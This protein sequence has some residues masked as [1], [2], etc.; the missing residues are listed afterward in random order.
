MTGTPPNHTVY[1]LAFERDGMQIYGNLY[2][3]KSEAEQYPITIIG[4][5]GSTISS[6]EYIHKREKTM[7]T[8]FV[9]RGDD[10][11]SYGEHFT[12]ADAFSVLRAVRQEGIWGTRVSFVYS[13]KKHAV[14]YVQNNDF[15][16]IEKYEFAQL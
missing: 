16:Q 13:M 11:N 12:V 3:P 7:C 9:Y 4:H 8:R 14:Y 2:L 6:K 10:M 5:G 1:E 15:S